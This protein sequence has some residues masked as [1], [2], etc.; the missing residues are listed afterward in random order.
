MSAAALPV[1][2]YSGPV[3]AHDAL[4]V[5]AVAATGADHIDDESLGKRGIPLLTLRGQTDVLR[6]LTPAAELS[7][8]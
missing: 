6:N 7:W 4:R 3:E 5:V 1:V 2:L 8:L